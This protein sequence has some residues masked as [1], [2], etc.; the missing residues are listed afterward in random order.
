MSSSHPRPA[1]LPRTRL[2]R[3]RL[4]WTHPPPYDVPPSVITQATKV[5]NTGLKPMHKGLSNVGRGWEMCM[6]MILLVLYGFDE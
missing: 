1:S 2:P 6:K 4:P 5:E 3:T